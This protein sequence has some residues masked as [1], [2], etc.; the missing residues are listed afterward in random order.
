MSFVMSFEVPGK[1][2]KIGEVGEDGDG[3]PIVEYVPI[4]CE[5]PDCEKLEDPGVGIRTHLKFVFSGEF[6]YYRPTTPRPN[7]RQ[8]E[9][10]LNGDY[11][12]NYNSFITSFS[13]ISPPQFKAD[14]RNVGFYL[15]SFEEKNAHFSLEY[16]IAIGNDCKRTGFGTATFVYDDGIVGTQGHGCYTP[17]NEIKSIQIVLDGDSTIINAKGTVTVMYHTELSP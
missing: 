15:G 9:I 13:A 10:A 3:K 6:I 8:L 12:Q 4:E 17:I 7:D 16:T 5:N 11:G 2:I 1:P 14:E